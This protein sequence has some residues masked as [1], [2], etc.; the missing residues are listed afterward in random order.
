M[1]IILYI[2]LQTVEAI[3]SFHNILNLVVFQYQ[4]FNISQKSY[5]TIEFLD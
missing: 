4:Q 1:N 5:C 3:E 2:Q